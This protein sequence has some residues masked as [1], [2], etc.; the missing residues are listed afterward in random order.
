[1]TPQQRRGHLYVLLFILTLVTFDL[2]LKVMLYSMGRLRPG[3]I[4]GTALALLLCYFLWRGSKAAHVVLFACAA[5]SIIYGFVSSALPHYMQVIFV[6][7]AAALLLALSAP[8]TR[9]FLA[10][11]RERSA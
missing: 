4:V 1:M 7:V 11:Q 10:Y 5:L 3:Q 9:S 2:A 6:I 8:A